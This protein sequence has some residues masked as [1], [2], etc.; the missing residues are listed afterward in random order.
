MSRAILVRVDVKD[1]EN[2]ESLIRRFLRACKKEEIEQT[3]R[4]RGHH[5]TKTQ[6]KRIK[7]EKSWARKKYQEAKKKKQDEK[8][9]KMM[10]KR[11]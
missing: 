6:K 10:L 5:L 11:I 9:R 4:E 2:S 8:N 3:V 1:G 7:R